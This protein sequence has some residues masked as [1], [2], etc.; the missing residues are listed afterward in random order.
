MYRCLIFFFVGL[1]V[2]GCVSNIPPATGTPSKSVEPQVELKSA[3]SGEM[4]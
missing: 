3:E 2:T 4:V 1:I